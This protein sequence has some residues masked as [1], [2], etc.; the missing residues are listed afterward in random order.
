MDDF[1][2]LI[3]SARHRIRRAEPAIVAEHREHVLHRIL[4][5]TGQT[6]DDVVNSRISKNIVAGHYKLHRGIIRKSEVR[7]LENQWNAVKL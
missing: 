7:E 3:P 5:F 6:I 1:N 4:A 2:S